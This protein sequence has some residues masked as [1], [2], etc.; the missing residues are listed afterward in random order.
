MTPH[1]VKIAVADVYPHAVNLLHKLEEYQDEIGTFT[2][3]HLEVLIQLNMLIY[4]L[5]NKRQ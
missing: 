2:N 4:D 3:A 1:E 5:E